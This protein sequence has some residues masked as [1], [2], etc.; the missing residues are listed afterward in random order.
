MSMVGLILALVGLLAVSSFPL[1]E[2]VIILLFLVLIAAYLIDNRFRSLIY[3]QETDSFK[4]NLEE[5]IENDVFNQK[6]ED[7]IDREQRVE[8]VELAVLP[9][10]NIEGQLSQ[11]HTLSENELDDDE[12]DIND[13]LFLEELND[14]EIDKTEHL[15]I[16]EDNDKDKINIFEKREP[17]SGYLSDIENLLLEESEA[18]NTDDEGWLEEFNELDS[19][20]K[21]TDPD[22]TDENVL[23]ELLIAVE[24]AAAGIEEQ[25]EKRDIERKVKLQK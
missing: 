25:K 13:Q 23:N 3:I 19:L 7:Q 22:K 24:E 6:I 5:E 9:T 10:L 14:I 18:V 2:T 8:N 16:E 11:E 1:W 21:I 20:A 12:I 17:E 15:T 4:L